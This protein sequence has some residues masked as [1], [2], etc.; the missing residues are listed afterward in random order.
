VVFLFKVF[1]MKNQIQSQKGFTLVE[2]LMVILIM[3]IL[4]R[5]AFSTYVDFAKDAKSTVTTSRLSELKIALLGDARMVSSGRFTS[6]GF[7]NQVGNVPVTLT[8]LAS[9]GTYSAY[10]P[11]NKKGW[12]GPYVNTSEP[13]WSKD[14]WG[15]SFQYNS[16]T[17][18]IKS[19]GPDKVCGNADDIT[20]TF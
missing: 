6:P 1:D 12:N 2:M 17:R 11:F 16:A 13:N 4:S 8:D 7:I 10:D 18:T 14:A 19:C 3:G 9:Q 5:V 15:I 20:V